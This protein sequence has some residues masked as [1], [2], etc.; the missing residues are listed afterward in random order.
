MRPPPFSKITRA[1]WIGGVTQVVEHLFASMK[2]GVQTPVI[3]KTKKNKKTMD[4][5]PLILNGIVFAQ[6]RHTSSSIL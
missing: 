1:K 5:F 3:P 2:P 4:A 6:N